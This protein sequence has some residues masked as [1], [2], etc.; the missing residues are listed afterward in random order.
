MDKYENRADSN[1]TNN[2]HYKRHKNAQ[3][4]IPVVL[5]RFSRHTLVIQ[6]SQNNHTL[7]V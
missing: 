3:I 6:S 1:N 7:V 4:G 2:T 5:S